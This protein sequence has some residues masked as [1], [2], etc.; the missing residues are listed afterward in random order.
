M[1]RISI[2]LFL[3]LLFQASA[4]ELKSLKFDKYVKAYNLII[5]SSEFTEFIFTNG[6]EE[7]CLSREVLPYY[8][9]G[10]YFLEKLNLD[11]ISYANLYGS[12]DF[13]E[14]LCHNKSFKTRLST[15]LC[16]RGFVT[17]FY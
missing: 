10:K 14:E 7:I 12:R 1:F 2:L 8:V 15:K 16:K 13:R 9:L 6:T 11:M 5:N 3:L 4:T 17:S